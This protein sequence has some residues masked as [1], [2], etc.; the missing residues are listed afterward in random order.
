[1]VGT[2]ADV[3]ER[4]RGEQELAESRAELERAAW[5]D[6][7]TGL[8]NRELLLDRLEQ[9]LARSRRNRQLLA[10]FYLDLDGFKAINDSMGHAAG[11]A[12][13]KQFAE[14]LRRAVRTSDTV[15]RLSGDEFVVLLEDLRGAKDAD[16]IA[17]TIVETAREEFTI[18]SRKLRVT[19]CV[20]V[21]F[22]KEE[23]SGAELLKLADTA[24]YQA[25]RSGR[26]RYHVAQSNEPPG[27]PRDP[28]ARVRP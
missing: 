18:D 13:L 6:A 9:A 26:D 11:D 19:T 8:P 15:A 25:K 21:A 7:L 10:V 5:H 28:P 22:A 1:M 23:L 20:G 14:R 3:T 27:A 4:K 24:L 17:S 2:N 12:L 16:V